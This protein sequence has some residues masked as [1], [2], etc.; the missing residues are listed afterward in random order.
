MADGRTTSR[1]QDTGLEPEELLQNLMGLGTSLNHSDVVFIAMY[2]KYASWATGKAQNA[3]VEVGISTLDMRH[4]REIHPSVS[5][6]GWIR[7]IRSRH[8][9]IT[10]WRTIFTTAMSEGHPLS[11]AKDFEFGKSESVDRAA[12]GDKIWNALHIMDDHPRGSRSY[13]KIVLVIN[14]HQEAGEYLGRVGITLSELSTVE[15]V[16]N[17]QDLEAAVGPLPVEAPV[18]LSGLLEQYGIEPLWFHNAGNQA[19][20]MLAVTIL[21]ALT[22]SSLGP[23]IFLHTLDGSPIVNANWTL[24]SLK[25]AVAQ[26]VGGRCIHCNMFGHLAPRCQNASISERFLRQVPSKKN[27]SKKNLNRRRPAFVQ[28]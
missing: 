11:C 14:G 10:E 19:S 24:E 9:R 12:L 2:I 15:A 18:S 5:G 13:R 28:K 20:Y 21:K 6:V 7:N 1:S 4:I 3:V 22:Q 27:P 17:L 26:K 16:L 8:I 25:A 23:H